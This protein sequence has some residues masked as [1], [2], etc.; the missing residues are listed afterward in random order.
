MNLFPGKSFSTSLL[1]IQPTNPNASF[2]QSKMKISTVL[3]NINPQTRAIYIFYI[4][5]V[6]LAE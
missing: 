2:V 5:A 6:N 1:H 3:L 4:D